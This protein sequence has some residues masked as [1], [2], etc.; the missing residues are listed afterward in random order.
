[1][2][3]KTYVCQGKHVPLQNMMCVGNDNENIF[4]Y[5]VLFPFLPDISE[6]AKKSP[7]FHVCSSLLELSSKFPLCQFKKKSMADVNITEFH[8]V[9]RKDFHHALT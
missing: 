5:T 9:W 3:A 2:Y 1:M 4:W 7:F 8:K 6:N